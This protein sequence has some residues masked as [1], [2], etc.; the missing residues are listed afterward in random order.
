[1]SQT[2][3]NDVQV[4]DTISSVIKKAG[5]PYSSKTNAQGEEEYTYIETFVYDNQLV[6]EN[7][8]TFVVK[9]GKVV[10][11]KKN[12]EQDPPYEMIYQDDPNHNYYP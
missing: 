11:K 6:Y 9:D 10:A 2:R 7:H 5:K 12:Q 3:Y 1:M 8:Y 4:G